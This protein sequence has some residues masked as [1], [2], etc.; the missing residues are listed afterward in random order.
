MGCDLLLLLTESHPFSHAGNQKF[1]C[2][3]SV[4][5][6]CLTIPC[7]IAATTESWR[8]MLPRGHL[9]LPWR[10]D[11][12]LFLEVQS[13]AAAVNICILW[14]P[15]LPFQLARL[16]NNAEQKI[17]C[18]KL[19]KNQISE[20][21]FHLEKEPVK[22]FLSPK[23]RGAGSSAGNFAFHTKWDLTTPIYSWNIEGFIYLIFFPA[24]DGKS[25]PGC[26]GR[27][28]LIPCT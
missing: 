21:C 24:A 3:I 27:Q 20:R 22:L 13:S 1:Q 10:W 23:S 9:C 2:W 19:K 12:V 25:P 17:I 16:H 15:S 8:K 14:V 11:L 28:K 6:Q 18:I 7:G 26:G 5:S 4:W